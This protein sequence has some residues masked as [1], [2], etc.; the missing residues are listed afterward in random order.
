MSITHTHSFTLSSSNGTGTPINGSVTEI[1]TTEFAVDNTFPAGTD[2]LLACTL[3]V[4][5]IQSIEMLSDKNLTIETNSGSSPANT[6]NLIAGVP[7]PWS[8]SA[9]YFPNPFGTNITALYIT[10][11][12]PARLKIKILT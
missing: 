9:A 2:V 8:K 5:N 4:A 7:F 6:I 3:T 12:V 1:G 11:A 10:N